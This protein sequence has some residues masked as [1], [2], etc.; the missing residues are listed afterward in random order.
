[1]T[2]SLT[3]HAFRANGMAVQ[4]AEVLAVIP[5]NDLVWSV[6]EFNGMGDAPCNFFMDDFAELVRKKPGGLM[7]SWDE[8]K[9]LSSGFSQT[10]DCVIVGA[11]TA[12]DILDAHK[13]EDD[14]SSCEVVL[15]AFDSTEWFVWSRDPSLIRK[16]EITYDDN[17]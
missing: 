2:E 5:D 10:I 13:A 9:K 1:M 16:F 14:F 7:M 17:K 3:F 6:L 12:Q 11:K 8:L 15:N 4:L